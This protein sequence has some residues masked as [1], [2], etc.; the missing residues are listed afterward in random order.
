MGLRSHCGIAGILCV[1]NFNLAK[2]VKLYRQL[3]FNTLK[4]LCFH[5]V[6]ISNHHWPSSSAAALVCLKIR[7]IVVL[8]LQE[9]LTS[10]TQHCQVPS[11][12]CLSGP[13]L[14]VFLNPW[15]VTPALPLCSQQS[16]VS[17]DL[18]SA[19]TAWFPDTP[20]ASHEPNT[21]GRGVWGLLCQWGYN[22]ISLWRNMVKTK[23]PATYGC[24]WSSHGSPVKCKIVN[25]RVLARFNFR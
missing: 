20:P 15:M 18:C 17:P 25:S 11:K 14:Q 23:I 3:R 8:R 1:W 5:T 2:H 4:P 22:N 19:F 16:C 9:L 21:G 24:W 7:T 6:F 13:C 10:W 12:P